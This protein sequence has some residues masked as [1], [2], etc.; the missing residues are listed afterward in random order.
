MRRKMMVVIVATVGLA[1]IGGGEAQAQSFYDGCP[2]DFLYWAPDYVGRQIG[3]GF[4]SVH[5]GRPGCPWLIIDVGG[6]QG[7][8]MFFAGQWAYF[9]P[10]SAAQCNGATYS[11]VA[12]RHDGGI[13]YTVVGSGTARGTWTNWFGTWFCQWNLVSGSWSTS[14][15]NSGPSNYRLLLRAWEANGAERIPAGSFAVNPRPIE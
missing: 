6:A 11:Y 7:K 4:S 10:S 15:N 3:V 8:N 12:A 5:I 13:L 1:A 2:S 9:Q 14:I